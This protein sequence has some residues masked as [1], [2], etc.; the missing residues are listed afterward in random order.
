MRRATAVLDFLAG[1]GIDTD[2]L[3]AAGEGLANPVASNDTRDG[4]A[5]NR[6]VEFEV[7]Q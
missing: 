2:R 3:E 5:Q 7:Q 4:R 1:H 6:R